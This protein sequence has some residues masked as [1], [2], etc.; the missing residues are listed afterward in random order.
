MDGASLATRA[1][2]RT[3]RIAC[4][5]RLDASTESVVMLA[6]RS[7]TGVCD[8]ESSDTSSPFESWAAATSSH[9]HQNASSASMGGRSPEVGEA[10]ALVQQGLGPAA[11]VF[12]E[13]G[14]QPLFILVGEVRG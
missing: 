14:P 6:S 12:G 8:I 5:S 11:L 4:G 1:A 7:S 9:R 2:S 3:R 13:D 10:P